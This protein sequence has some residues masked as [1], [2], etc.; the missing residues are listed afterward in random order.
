MRCTRSSSLSIVVCLSF[1]VNSS[2][3][4]T[5][6][7]QRVLRVALASPTTFALSLLSTLGTLIGLVTGGALRAALE[8][9]V[10]Q[11]P[12]DRVSS[13]QPRPRVDG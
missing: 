4:L 9:Q 3:R 5:P 7:R 2:P 10:S 12:S 11:A 13:A 1:P 8:R 6:K